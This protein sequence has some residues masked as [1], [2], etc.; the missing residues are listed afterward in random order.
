RIIDRKAGSHHA[1]RRIDV[2]EDFLFGVLRLQE[3]QLRHN[4]RCHVIFD[5]SGQEDDAFAQE[6]RIDIEAPLA[7][8]GIL[9]YLRNEIV[10]VD[11]NWTAI[12]QHGETFLFR[13]SGAPDPMRQNEKPSPAWRL[14]GP[15]S[16]ETQSR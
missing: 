10:V 12:A 2:H 5:R 13:N 1:T 14:P 3:E 6:P 4:H 11:F 15:A 7:P 8:A 16:R 9:D